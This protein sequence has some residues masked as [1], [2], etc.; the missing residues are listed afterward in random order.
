MVL[1][2]SKVMYA[3]L[4]LLSA[5]EETDVDS[6]FRSKDIFLVLG[7]ALLLGDQISTIQ[8]VGY[9]CVFSRYCPAEC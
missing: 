4:L 6:V 3:T 7:S 9:A 1:S 5:P 8:A 2:L